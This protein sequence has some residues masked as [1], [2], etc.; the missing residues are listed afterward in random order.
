MAVGTPQRTMQLVENGALKLHPKLVVML[1]CSFRDARKRT[2]F[3]EVRNVDV[4]K[5][6]TVSSAMQTTST[7]YHF[8]IAY[9]HPFSLSIGGRLGRADALFGEAHFPAGRAGG[10]SQNIPLLMSPSKVY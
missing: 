10:L 3:E 1:D 6:Y 9:A 7:L 8:I 5:F 2:L 4:T